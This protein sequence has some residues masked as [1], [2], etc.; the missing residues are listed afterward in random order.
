MALDPER[1]L[2]TPPGLWR[3]A[4]S[5]VAS[6]RAVRRDAWWR[7]PHFGHACLDEAES[8]VVDLKLLAQVAHQP[9]GLWIR[10]RASLTGFGN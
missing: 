3:S 9:A 8:L 7:A 10:P 2:A 4:A 5:A 1:R 6:A